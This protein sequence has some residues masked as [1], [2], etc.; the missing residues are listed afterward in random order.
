MRP[1]F[2]RDRLRHQLL[3]RRRGEVEADDGRRLDDVPLHRRELVQAGREQGVDRRWDVHAGHGARRHPAT[4]PVA[5]GAAVD[6]HGQELLHEQRVALGRRDDR[7]PRVGRE[8]G[9]PEQVVDDRLRV[10]LGQRRQDGPGLVFTFGPVGSLVEQLVARR[11]QDQEGR[12]GRGVH[13]VSD[14]IQEGRLGPVD[15]VEQDHHRLVLAEDLQEPPDPPEQLG[16]LE[17]RGLQADGGGDPVH[18]VVRARTQQRRQPATSGL[19]RILLADVGGLADHLGHRPERDAVA[20]REAAAAQHAGM[21][22]DRIEEL[23][24]EARLPDPGVP[25]DRDHPRAAFDGGRG[26]RR[27]EQGHLRL[28][29]DHR[30]VLAPGERLAAADRQQVVRG[31]RL[32]LALEDERLHRLHVDGVADEPVGQLPE[33]DASIRRLLLQSGGHVHRIA[34]HQ[35]LAEAG[36]AGDH[37]AGVHAGRDPQADLL[38]GGQ[39]VGQGGQAGGQFQRRTDRAQPV[40]LVADRQAE[41]RH[42][43]VPDELLDRPT[44]RGQH[45]MGDLEGPGHD[46]ALTLGRQRLAG[47]VGGTE[48]REH[49]RHGLAGVREP[50][51]PGRAGGA[52]DRRR[53]PARRG[54]AVRPRGADQEVDVA[55][56]GRTTVGTPA[57]GRRGVERLDGRRGPGARDRLR[58]HEDTGGGSVLFQARRPGDHLAGQDVLAGTRR[59]EDRDPAGDAGADLQA[60]TPAR[61]EMLVEFGDRGL[62]LGS[63][64]HRAYRVIGPR[65]GDA[66]DGHDGVPD[67]LLDR[68]A[69]GLD[70]RPHGVEVEGQDLAQ[71]LGVETLAEACRPLEV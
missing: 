20:V 16:D 68:P 17:R 40:I 35:P 32:R 56:R 67:D 43:G 9:T 11:A 4:V 71:G 69:V 10:R 50:G 63:G 31:D 55:E 61:M 5:Q 24:G 47:P 62:G 42:D 33:V 14:E 37:F 18:D 22:A 7:G 12:I 26:Q 30:R 8:S 25:D 65:L 15:V 13:E 66:E 51:L 2:R 58:V 28:A 6:E 41:H 23:A 21:L 27:A 1:E 48:V 64:L 29:P 39:G 19:R 44:V 54:L 3:E 57:V 46:I 49:D 52:L 53:M 70:D 36:V 45:A 38:F 34:R 60:D 59:A